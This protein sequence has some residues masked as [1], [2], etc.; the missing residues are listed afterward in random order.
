MGWCLHNQ[1]SFWLDQQKFI[2]MLDGEERAF[3]GEA[4]KVF[5]ESNYN[6]GD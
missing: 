1:A 4:H 2:P 6:C 3:I 5:T